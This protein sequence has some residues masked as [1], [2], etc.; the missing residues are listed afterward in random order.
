MAEDKKR[1]K[2]ASGTAK[3][4]ED[5]SEEAEHDTLAAT[6]T[7]GLQLAVGLVIVALVAGMGIGY[8]I[9]PKSDVPGVSAPSD[10]GAPALTPDQ[11]N[12]GQLPPGHV[13]IDETA[14]P[15]GATQTPAP[16]E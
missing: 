10:T 1:T 11:L 6:P 3:P 7:V 16:T 8:T 9:A 5:A 4:K 14:T 13:P 2:K 12:E 15:G